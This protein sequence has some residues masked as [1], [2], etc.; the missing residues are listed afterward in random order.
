MRTG[1]FLAA[2]TLTLTLL[3]GT[4]AFA[5]EPTAT[6]AGCSATVTGVPGQP[7][8]LTPAS[9]TEPLTSA[10]SGLDPLGVLTSAFRT[11]WAT[12]APIPVGTVPV[13]QAEIPGARIADAVVAR[14]GELPVLAPVLTPLVSTVRG[15][16]AALCG[17]VVRGQVPGAPPATAPAP[18]ADPAP[19]AGTGGLAA[20]GTPVEGRQWTIAAV[21]GPASSG[22]AVFGTPIPG[23]LPGDGFPASAGSGVPQA[24][25]GAPVVLDARRA[26]GSADPL[27]APQRD[28]L[29]WPVMAA[30]LL[31][32]AVAAQLVRRW[33]LR[34]GR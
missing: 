33:G 30:I 10:L 34:A 8:A 26:A 5:D 15:S 7:V 20:G 28:A 32:A 1:S 22:G 6:A 17:I 21:P 2:G 25:S 4:P 19:P 3:A 13:G 12:T 27:A 23:Q 14:L 31:L 18:P 9:V 24:G 29:S 11:V 16:L